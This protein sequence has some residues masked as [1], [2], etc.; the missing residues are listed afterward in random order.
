MLNFVYLRNIGC[1]Q[2]TQAV[3]NL[4]FFTIDADDLKPDDE[5]VRRIYFVCSPTSDF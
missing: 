1:E 2:L 4:V 3:P 5:E